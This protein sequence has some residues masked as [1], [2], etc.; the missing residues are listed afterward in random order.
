M[1]YDWISFTT[2][3]GLAD[4]F[5]A[6]CEGVIARI[7]PNAR[8]LH[9][10]HHVPAQDVRRGAEVL[11]QAVPYLPPGVHL[12]VVDPGVGTARRAVA[13]ATLGGVL[14]GPDNGLLVPAA[15]ALGGMVAAVELTEHRLEPV[16]PTF[17]GRDVFAP[18]AAHLALGRPLGELGPEVDPGA[19]VR[20]PAPVTSAVPGR[21]TTEVLGADGF[22]NVQLAAVGPDLATAGAAPGS[23]VHVE[24]GGRSVEAVVGRTFGDVAAGAAVV[25]LDSAGRVAVA[26]NGGSAQAVFGGRAGDRAVVLVER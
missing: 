15:E 22:G 18:A 5:P 2:D 25:L 21:L 14:V 12:A 3:Y 17:H 7:A 24:I 1:A 10:T 4:G 6:I 11:A 8:V 9:V 20:L 19:L 23:G 13:V 16:S 26:V